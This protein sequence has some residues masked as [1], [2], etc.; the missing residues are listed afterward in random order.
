MKIYGFI[1]CRSGSKGLPNKNIK[2]MNGISLLKRNIMLL[3]KSKNI[4]K[5]FVSTDSEEYK[6]EALEAGAIVPVLR[7]KELSEDNSSEI[8]A[9]KFMVNYLKENNDNFDIFISLP[10]ISPLKTLDDIDNIINQFK[11]NDSELLITVK[12]S[13]RNPYFNMIKEIDNKITIFDESLTN[14]SN[15]QNFPKV[16][17]ITTVAYVIKR[18]ILLNLKNNLFN[19]DLK[20]DKYIVNKINGIDIDDID[21]FKTAEYFHKERI[22]SRIDFSVL[23]NI[24]LDEKIA[25]ITG[26]IGKIGEKI[27]ETLLELNCHVIIIDF[28]SDYSRKKIEELNNKFETNIDFFNIDLS[29]KEKINNFCK[30]ILD[31]Y[32]KIDILINCAALVG[33]SG[34]EGWAE[35]FENQSSEA[36]DMCMN[37]NVKAPMLL[38]QGLLEGFKKSLNPK[39]INISSIYG[40]RGN[41]FSLYEDT[42]MKSPIAYSISK[43]GLNIMTKYLASWY[44]S[45]NICINSVV[46]GGIFRNQD[47]KFVER[48]N[49]KTPLGRMGTE[50]DIKGI[51]S[52]LS[53]NLSNYITGQEFVVDGGITCKF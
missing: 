3:R 15:R 27:V 21:D 34:L 52:F 44:G 25:V 2:K 43:A 14:I 10:V 20:I 36:F 39:I 31:R 4:D 41:D 42:N 53:S 7:P 51:I 28:E 11:K 46:L 13:E 22:K 23:N 37:V 38:I 45:S 40:I 8:D 6:K 35:S 1:F 18:D 12:N 5:I 9:W 17:D 29:K 33:T 26:G 16:F 47:I 32:Q 48:Y 19:S 49:K 30:N 50:D 24:L